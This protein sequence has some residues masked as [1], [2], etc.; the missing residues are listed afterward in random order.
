VSRRAPA[1]AAAVVAA[2]GVL[3]GVPPPVPAA[4]DGDTSCLRCHTDPEWFDDQAAELAASFEDDVHAAAGLS[5]HDC[6]G[7]NP[8]LEVAEDL[9]AA[10]DPEYAENPYL[11]V[12]ERVGIPEFCGRCHS[13]PEYMRRFQPD[14]RV[15]QEREYWTSQHGVELRAGNG[16]VATCVDCHGGH[17]VLGPGDASSP[18]YP[19]R[20][21]ET[22][23][24]CH[25]DRDTM[26]GATLPDGR[27][28]PTDQFVRWRRSVHAA[29]LHDKG[30]F[31]APTCNDCHGNH[32]AAP[33]GIDSITFVCGQCHGREAKLFRDSPK[34][35]GYQE[36]NLYLEGM[37]EGCAGCHEAPEPQAALTSVHSFTECSTCH[38]NHAVVRPTVAML[39]PLPASPCVFCH[40]Q[41]GVAG[42][43]PAEPEPQRRSY[44]ETRD[45]LLASAREE[46]LDGDALFD[47]LV[48]RALDLP[49]HTLPAGEGE[50]P[51]LRPEFERL[52]E[53]FR[54][55]KTHYRY[56]DPDGEGTVRAEV[57]RCVSC[58]GPEV[59]IGE[60]P[61]GYETAR[62]ILDSM[63]ELTA[64]TARAERI[65]LAARRGG[66]ETREALPEIDR[67]VDA[68]IGLEV[69]VHAF[70]AG[71]ESDFAERHQEGVAA[72]T[73]ALEAGR[74]AL[75][76]LAY[77]RRGLAVA[78][79]FIVLVAV[80]L[81]L[82]I[83]QLA[84]RR[85]P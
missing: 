41:G 76:E 18:V 21:A 5:C 83:R 14:P 50:E 79:I 85:S 31:S 7:G 54:I 1:L 74:E 4:G 33:P 6:H 40:E 15:D 44:E 43:V 38:G 36:H 3:L 81:A 22:C 29:A 73:T 17:G 65:V 24:G 16:K 68:Q 52:F 61:A 20:V 64:L 2:V 77:R 47:H 19:L 62:R 11:G 46:G 57:V 67:A 60:G 10:M 66:V 58:H 28:L 69:L 23:R 30:D 72:A 34:E 80:G 71:E 13:D 78:L 45:R 8:S 42:E 37:D 48:D 55:G 49:E 51:A 82:K 32:G 35:A 70:D 75:G 27:P 63:R 12:P 26:A 25:G 56:D 59:V 84:S 39:G 53:K 9:D